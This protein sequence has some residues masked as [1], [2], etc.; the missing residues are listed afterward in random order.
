MFSFLITSGE[1]FEQNWMTIAAYLTIIL[2]VGI[3]LILAYG[4][5]GMTLKKLFKKK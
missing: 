5:I 1:V 2:V 3:P 4:F